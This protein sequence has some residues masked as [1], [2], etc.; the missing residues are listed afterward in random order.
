MIRGCYH[1]FTSN[2][3]PDTAAQHYFDVV[4]RLGY[5][6]IA[7]I[8]D[9]ED[10]GTN[11]DS[12]IS[13]VRNR[14]L[15]TMQAVEKLFSRSPILYTNLNTIQK[16]GL[17]TDEFG[18]YRLWLAE[19]GVK[20][21]RVPDAWKDKGI[22]IWQKKPNKKYGNSSADYDLYNGKLCDIYK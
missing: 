2:S 7:Q 18:Q 14:L 16:Y 12:V 5:R 4:G 10:D 20:R 8:I 9:F 1:F 17:S 3:V 19:W 13:E 15:Q 11:K 22:F 6:E 21:P